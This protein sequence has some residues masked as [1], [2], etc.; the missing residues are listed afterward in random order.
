MNDIGFYIILFALSLFSILK[1][2]KLLA[3]KN[4]RH[5]LFDP[6][7]LIVMFIVLI[8][9][10]SLIFD[11]FRKWDIAIFF[12]FG[13]NVALLRFSDSD[14]DVERGVKNAFKFAKKCP[15]CMKKLPS[16]FTSRCPHCTSNLK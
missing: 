8:I 6:I 4:E 16:V 5:R 10:F 13:V 2:I 1:T 7:Y 12:I 11:D 3:D 9:G 15:N 14:Y